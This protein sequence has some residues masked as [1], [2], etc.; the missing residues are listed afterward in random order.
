VY[1]IAPFH[2]VRKIPISQD[3][4][5]ANHVYPPFLCTPDD[6]LL[7]AEYDKGEGPISIAYIIETQLGPAQ[8]TSHR[9]SVKLPPNAELQE[10]EFAPQGDRA[11]WLIRQQSVPPWSAFLH[12]LISSYPAKPIVVGSIW[13]SRIDGTE[14]HE[15]GHQRGTDG[16][17]AADDLHWLPDGKHLSYL[18]K[19][20]V[21]T[22][23]VE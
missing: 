8:T 13:I 17:Q 2:I 7:V 1:D 4:P 11:A 10:V 22:V 9:Y 6:H 14:M 15:L 5:L 23:P 16:G 12:R 3:S 18:Y 20:L 21:Y 19:G